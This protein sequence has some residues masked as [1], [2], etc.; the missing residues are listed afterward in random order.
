[1][2]TSRLLALQLVADLERRIE[3]LANTATDTL[4]SLENGFVKAAKSY[5][6][7]KGITYATWRKAGVPAALLKKAGISRTR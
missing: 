6:E 3:T 7:S 5:G 1:V 2:G 4:E